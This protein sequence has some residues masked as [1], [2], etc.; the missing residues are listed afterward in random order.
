M[1]GE[2]REV[3]FQLLEAKRGLLYHSERG[4]LRKTNTQL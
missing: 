4:H 3:S 1:R 2:V